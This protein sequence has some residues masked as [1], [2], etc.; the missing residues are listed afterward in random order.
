MDDNITRRLENCYTGVIYD[1]M[2][3]W[4]MIISLLQKKRPIIPEKTL[5]SPVFTIN[6]EVDPA[7]NSH[8]TLL[9]YT[10]LFL[11]APAGFERVSQSND[12]QVAHM[13]E[14]SAET[15]QSRGIRGAIID[16]SLRDVN[17]I[18]KIKFQTWCRDF[19]P[20]DIAG[21]WRH[22]P[23]DTVIMIGD[24]CVERGDYWIGNRDGLIFMPSGVIDAVVSNAGG[25]NE[26]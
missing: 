6:G 2:S 14:L 19:T 10:N 26:Y 9:A 22:K 20:R 8:E 24:V 17:F 25:S 21:Y 12:E 3:R 23:Y 4:V 18:L 13:G 5:V 11:A 1:V 15:L 7:A 16:G